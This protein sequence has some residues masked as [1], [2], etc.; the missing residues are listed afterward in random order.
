MELPPGVS[1]A[2]LSVNVDEINAGLWNFVG[3]LALIHQLLFSKPLVIT[4]GRD[5]VHAAG[6]LHAE[7]KAVDVRTKGLLP[8][9]QALLLHVLAYAGPCSDVATFDERALP[10]QEHIH[11][12]WHGA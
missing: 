7:G 3:H 12:E 5:S 9:E 10:G 11:L 8:D 1:L 2:S 4:S 6:S